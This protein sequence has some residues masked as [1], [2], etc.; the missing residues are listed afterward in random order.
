MYWDS[1]PYFAFGNGATS[2]SN[3]RFKMKRFSRPKDLNDYKEFVNTLERYGW[4]KTMAMYTQK[5]K[6]INQNSNCRKEEHYES[7]LDVI[8]EW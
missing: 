7:K 4:N 6:N 5:N 2:Y 3:N 8:F 1:K